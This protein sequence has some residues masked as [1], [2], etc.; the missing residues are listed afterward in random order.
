MI[1]SETNRNATISFLEDIGAGGAGGAG[2]G[3]GGAGGAG[4]GAGGAGGGGSGGAR[5][6]ARG[7]GAG[8]DGRTIYP[9]STEWTHLGNPR[10]IDRPSA[11][12]SLRGGL[13]FDTDEHRDKITGDVRR[14]GE[15]QRD[16][17]RSREQQLGNYAHY[18]WNL[19]KSNPR[20]NLNGL[21]YDVTLR[22][23]RLADVVNNRL[24]WDPGTA[25]TIG[26]A[27]GP[28]TL[29]QGTG[30][31]ERWEPIE[32][33]EMR[34]MQANREIDRR[35]REAGVDLQSRIQAYPQEVQE[36]MDEKLRELRFHIAK[37]DDDFVSWFQKNYVETEYN[38]S[39]QLYFEQKMRQYLAELD[40]DTKSRIY[41]QL[42]G[43][44]PSIANMIGQVFTN[45]WQSI[46][47]LE[48]WIAKF[49]EESVR[50]GALDWQ[51]LLELYSMINSVVSE[52]VRK[53]DM[54]D[55]NAGF[56][57]ELPEGYGGVTEERRNVARERL[58]R[59]MEKFR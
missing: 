1:G 44:V 53:Y 55:F 49:T 17:A 13:A 2:G 9:V 47:F 26:G 28:I 58:R 6:G 52:M 54:H 5:G 42:A 7:G 38:R 32:T 23:S 11:E 40:L 43:K 37:M 30:E 50:T 10:F 57:G 27:D 24:H 48:F 18:D 22:M 39:W 46:P 29:G 8:V 25:A 41:E 16:A 14:E 4:G 36:A 3:A 34:Q 20:G 21:P 12:D 59:D 45:G 33:E 19:A 56:G 51:G 35:A 31:V 15:R